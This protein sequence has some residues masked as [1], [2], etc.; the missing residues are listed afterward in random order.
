MTATNK[1]FPPEIVDN[2]TQVVQSEIIPVEITT[3]H[4]NSLDIPAVIQNN[5]QTSRQDIQVAAESTV[6]TIDLQSQQQQGKQPELVANASIASSSFNL[7]NTILG[8]GI[9]TIPYCFSKTGWVVGIIL[10]VATALISH[11]TFTSLCTG[12]QMSNSFD[13]STIV[14]NILGKYAGWYSTF[15]LL[16]FTAFVM[17]S[18]CIIT[19]DNLIF[20]KQDWAKMLV[21]WL[22]LL[23]MM[24]TLSLFKDINKLWITSFLAVVCV[25][26]IFVFL[27]V[28]SIL[29][30]VTDLDLGFDLKP[31]IAFGRKILPYIQA[32]ATY[33]LC[34]C[35]HFNTTNIYAELKDRSP[36]KMNKVS[37]ITA[38][39]VLILNIG[40]GMGGYFIF[41]D[42]VASDVL[43]SFESVPNANL[44][45]W[46]IIAHLAIIIVMI[47]SYPLLCFCFRTTL[48]KIIFKNKVLGYK[49]QVIVVVTASLIFCL[50]A[51]FLNDI[52]IVLDIA[53]AIA[54]I[55]LVLV[56]PGFIQH[57]YQKRV[58][59][60]WDAER[61]KKQYRLLAAEG[62]FAFLVGCAG[63]II[64]GVGI[65]G[66]VTSI[67][68]V[69]E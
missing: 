69:E 2:R 41:T 37:A 61:T 67:M 20:I 17:V 45:P 30:R 34:F 40:I 7:I 29:V 24:M 12:S 43:K 48:N 39:S 5:Q 18:F 65:S 51:S 57:K 15:S 22:V 50:V 16:I 9:L 42:T 38:Y 3:E 10:Q 32:L 54:G 52:G 66:S 6:A 13:Y 25:S 23:F 62:V 11:Y 36:K 31:P 47:C 58:Y 53:S 8:A 1:D 60:E 56:F 44:K 14:K 59:K 64:V 49:H 4:T 26:Y 28:I 33:S 35:G 19:R 55:P 46:C 21:M 68:K 27:V 63:V